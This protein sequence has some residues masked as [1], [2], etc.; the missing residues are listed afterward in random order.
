MPTIIKLKRH[1]ATNDEDLNKTVPAEGE[2]VYDITKN[3]LY[4]GDGSKTLSE[5]TPINNN[6]SITTDKFIKNGSIVLDGGVQELK[7]GSKTVTLDIVRNALNYAAID[8]DGKVGEVTSFKQ[9]F[10]D[11]DTEMIAIK[12][13]IDTSLSDRLVWKD[14][15]K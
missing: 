1:K 10:D 4:I 12:N 15:D 13:S 5:L 9:K 3:E 2:P 14:L 8:E 11:I 6:F 7:L